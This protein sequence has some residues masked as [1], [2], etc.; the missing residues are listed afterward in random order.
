MSKRIFMTLWTLIAT[1]LVWAMSVG[2]IT[3]ATG[4]DTT[5]QLRR[6]WK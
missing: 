6:I 1:P 3:V 4:I 2:A 5:N